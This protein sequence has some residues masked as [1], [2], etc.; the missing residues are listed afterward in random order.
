LGVAKI[1]DNMEIGHNVMHGQYDFMNDP[2]LNSREFDWD[3]VC[4]GESW[5]RTHNFEHH[6][7]TNI[8]GKDRD[9]GYET[10]RL[11]DDTP[12]KPNNRLQIPMYIGMTLFFQWGVAYHEMIGERLFFGKPK[13]DSKL[14][15]SRAQLAKDFFA[16]IRKATF[17]DYL[18]YPAVVGI[19]LGWPMFFA[20]LAGNAAANL[21]RNI[22]ASAIIFCGHFTENVHTF[23]EAECENETRGQWYYRQILGSSNI[24]GSKLLHIMT[25]HLSCQVE[26]HLFP[27][28]PSYRYRE[29]SKKVQAVCEQHGIPYNTGSLL[30]QY[31]E[32]VQR[33]I[34]YGRKPKSTSNDS[35][36]A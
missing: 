27:S 10:L 23:S 9:F 34:K 20:I 28:M 36:T 6:T 15:I 25:G 29:V 17:R 4:D 5:R 7:Y 30:G 21:I 22:W 14:P 16:K 13:A 31:T 12:W 26:H 33:I 35:V 1:L 2:H 19:L 18:F 3:N 8:I 11:S 32:V 24:K